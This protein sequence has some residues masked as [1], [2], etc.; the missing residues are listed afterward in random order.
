MPNADLLDTIL[1]FLRTNVHLIKGEGEIQHG[2]NFLK[3]PENFKLLQYFYPTEPAKIFEESLFNKTLKTLLKEL[4]EGILAN[5]NCKRSVSELVKHTRT[6]IKT[7]EC[8]N[9]LNL[10]K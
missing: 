1:I 3:F 6:L 9:S 8:I 5:Q 4:N 7:L 2:A 10:N